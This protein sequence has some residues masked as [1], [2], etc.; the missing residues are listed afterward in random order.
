MK[1]RTTRRN[2]QVGFKLVG[3]KLVGFD[4]KPIGNKFAVNA[5]LR[6]RKLRRRPSEN[7][8]HQYL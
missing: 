3:F 8:V 1:P 4:A 2:R 5:G 7:G 6:R